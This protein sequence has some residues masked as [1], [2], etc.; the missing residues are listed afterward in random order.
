MSGYALA[1]RSE[2]GIGL[3]ARYSAPISELNRSIDA[4]GAEPPSL[5]LKGL[6]QL[7]LTPQWTLG[8]GFAWG[9]AHQETDNFTDPSGVPCLEGQACRASSIVST[10][11]SASLTLHLSYTPWDWLSP[12]IWGE[13]GAWRRS[14][15]EAYETLSTGP[16]ALIAHRYAQEVWWGHKLIVG[17]GLYWRFLSRW[18]TILGVQLQHEQ[19]LTP[20]VP[21]SNHL[22]LGVSIWLNYHYYLRLF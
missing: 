19:V 17:G 13:V 5:E 14:R 8:A 22:T 18:S 10:T 11:H 15:S 21:R 12:T 3:D 2:L 20:S 9:Y 16:S 1:D 7:G 6:T 4:L